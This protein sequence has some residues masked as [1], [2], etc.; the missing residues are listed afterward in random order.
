MQRIGEAKSWRATKEMFMKEVNAESWQE[1][2]E[3]Y[4]PQKDRL[5]EF[6]IKPQQEVPE[7]F[8]VLITPNVLSCI[9]ASHSIVVSAFP[10]T[11]KFKF[12]TLCHDFT[13]R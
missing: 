2:E 1:V 11:V 4:N 5:M 12:A 3:Q 7:N 8:K 13:I 6:K 10:L 9:I